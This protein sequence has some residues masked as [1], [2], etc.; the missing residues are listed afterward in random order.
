MSAPPA[1]RSRKSIQNSQRKALRVWYND[2]SNGKQSLESASQWWLTFYGYKLNTSTV[3]EILSQKW[4]HLDDKSIHIWQ[5]SRRTREAKW[6]VLEDALFE[7]MQRYEAGNNQLTGAILRQKAEQFWRQ[8]PCYQGL[9]QPKLSEGW[10][11]RL[12]N[13]YNLRQRAKHGE[14][15]SADNIDITTEIMEEREAESD[16]E[17]EVVAK[18]SVAEAL[19]AL[20]TLKIYEEQQDTGDPALSKA[21]RTRERELRL[22]KQADTYQG[23]LDG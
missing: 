7:W 10:I 4:A 18:V 22:T 15:G 19:S 21:L 14:A 5:D 3:S 2:D 20:V 17:I 23:K 13:R 6:T 11:T 8:L 9:P 12:K 16:K 1:K